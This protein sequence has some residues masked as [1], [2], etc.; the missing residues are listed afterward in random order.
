MY[1]IRSYYVGPDE[2]DRDRFAETEVRCQGDNTHSS[3][4][5]Q[6]IQ[7]ILAVDFGAERQWKQHLWAN[8]ATRD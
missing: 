3:V 7:A 8:H 4:A 6:A 1:A 5:N 2:L